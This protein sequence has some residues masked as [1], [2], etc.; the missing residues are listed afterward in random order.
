MVKRVQKFDHNCESFQNF[1]DGIKTE[2]TRRTYSYILDDLVRFANYT[3]Y[4]ELTKLDDDGIHELLKQ[5]IRY[6]K[7]KGLAYKTC[8]LK[9]NAVEHFFEMN[10]RIIF[11]NYCQ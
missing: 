9:L 5:W 6:F 7:Q 4:D 11:E 10:K 2:T 3:N 1:D 8:K